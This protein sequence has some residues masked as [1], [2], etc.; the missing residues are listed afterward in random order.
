[1]H[2]FVILEIGGCEE[3]AL[4]ALLSS[5]DDSSV[6]AEEQTSDYGHACNGIKV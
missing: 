6:V 5:R 2:Y 3:E 4:Q 1:M